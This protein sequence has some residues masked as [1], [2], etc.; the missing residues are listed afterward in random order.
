MR[1]TRFLCAAALVLSPSMAWPQGY[2][3]GPEFRVNTYT[4]GCQGAPSVAADAAGNFVVVWSGGPV[5]GAND[6]YGQR[7]AS[8]GTP[9]GSEFR[10]NSY[11]TNSQGPADVATDTLGN[12]V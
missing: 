3:V 10:I 6:V 11:T 8:T 1:P 7:F 9:L 2:P 5:P 12:F 4:T